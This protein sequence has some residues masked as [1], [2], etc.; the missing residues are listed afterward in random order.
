[1]GCDTTTAAG[2][3]T[4]T[5]TLLLPHPVHPLAMLFSARAHPHHTIPKP[6]PGTD[7]RQSLA[8]ACGRVDANVHPFAPHDGVKRLLLHTRQPLKLGHYQ[9]HRL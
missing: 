2:P 5:L 3:P 4:L 6:T 8:R 7:S 9:R 1:M